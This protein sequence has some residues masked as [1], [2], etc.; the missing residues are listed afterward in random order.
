[1]PFSKYLPEHMG[2]VDAVTPG[3]FVA[4]THAELVLIY[5]AGTSASTTPAC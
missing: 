4:G 1:M 2:S 5:T 3:P